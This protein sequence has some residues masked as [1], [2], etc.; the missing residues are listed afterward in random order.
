M[1]LFPHKKLFSQP[2]FVILIDMNEILFHVLVFIANANIKTE[3]K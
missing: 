3:K 1:I 2:Q